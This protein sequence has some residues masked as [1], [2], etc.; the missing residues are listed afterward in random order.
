M[1]THTYVRDV[2][3]PVWVHIMCV[4]CVCKCALRYVSLH[5]WVCTDR[6]VH[7]TM[8]RCVFMHECECAGM[9]LQACV[10]MHV[11]ECALEPVSMHSDMCLCA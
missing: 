8:F 9:C 11:Y 1:C 4:R 6:H 2:Y 7:E 10:Y 3:G 5:V